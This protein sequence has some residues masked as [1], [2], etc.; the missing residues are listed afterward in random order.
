[1]PSTMQSVLPKPIKKFVGVVVSYCFIKNI[2]YRNSII[3]D[4]AIAVDCFD[5]KCCV[6]IASHLSRY[7]WLLPGIS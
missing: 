3:E 2:H 4:T 7:V 1:L 6:F 5:S